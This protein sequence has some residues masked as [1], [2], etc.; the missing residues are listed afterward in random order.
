MYYFW[1]KNLTDSNAF[2]FFKILLKKKKTN[3]QMVN[4]VMKANITDEYCQLF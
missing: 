2:L 1:G 4:A 3:G